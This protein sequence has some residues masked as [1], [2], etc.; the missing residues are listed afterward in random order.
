MLTR[1]AALLRLE[2]ELAEGFQLVKYEPGQHYHGHADYH[3]GRVGVKG[4]NGNRGFYG[5]AMVNRYAT[6]LYYLSDV[7][8]GGATCFPLANATTGLHRRR[9]C[10]PI[11]ALGPWLF[12]RLLG[13]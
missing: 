6:L 8:D 11:G 7:F 13:C 5:D 9:H 10:P 12:T 2:P 3:T 1:A 4:Y